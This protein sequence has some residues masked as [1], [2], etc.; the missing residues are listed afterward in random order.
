MKRKTLIIIAVATLVTTAFGVATAQPRPSTEPVDTAAPPLRFEPVEL[1]TRKFME[2]YDSIHLTPE[3]E[4]IKRAALG[5]LKAVCCKEFSALTCCCPCNFSKSLWG[6]AHHLIAEK[7]YSA[8]Q[9]EEAARAWIAYVNP[10]GFTGD[11]C[12]TGGCS[13][14]F[15][16]NGCGGMD[17]KNVVF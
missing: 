7:G 16:R 12:D 14:P 17:E 2:A 13:R 15:A 1:Q 11:A 3:Q 5:P 10:K 6:M 9:V 4:E 8:S